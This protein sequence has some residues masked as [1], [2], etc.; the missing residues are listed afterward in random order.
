MRG[1]AVCLGPSVTLCCAC[2]NR[3]M[4]REHSDPRHLGCHV[5]RAKG[6]RAPAP[7]GDGRAWRAEAGPRRRPI[8]WPCGSRSSAPPG[9]R[10]TPSGGQLPGET[11]EVAT[12]EIVRARG[13]AD[14][15]ARRL[16]SDVTVRNR[17]PVCRGICSN[18]RRGQSG[19]AKVYDV[20]T[21]GIA[22]AVRHSSR[23]DIRMRACRR[24]ERQNRN[25]NH[26]CLDRGRGSNRRLVW[27]SGVCREQTGHRANQADER[28]SAPN[29][30]PHMLVESQAR[31]PV[32]FGRFPAFTRPIFQGQEARDVGV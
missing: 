20:P 18:R 7:G 4:L 31:S 15:R 23:F 24:D 2:D 16:L 30:A 5:A 27:P 10:A 26:G 8:T 32:R 25:Q 28:D 3:P 21:A 17:R 9:H 29:P 14:F 13:S 11:G 6:L 12:A 1:T 19:S 22:C